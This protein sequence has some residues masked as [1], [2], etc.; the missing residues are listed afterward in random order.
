M[1]HDTIISPLAEVLPDYKL[2]R[3][4]VNGQRAIKKAKG[5]YLPTPD[6][7]DTSVAGLARY[8]TYLGRAVFYGVT[9]R[10]LRGLVG[11]V[12]DKDPALEIPEMLRPLIADIS[13]S[14]MTL[15]EQAEESLSDNVALGRT[16][17]LTDYPVTEGPV[18]RAEALAGNIL[19]TIVRYKAE[20]IIN[21]R[22]RRIGARLQTTLVVLREDAV[23]DDDGF[24]EELETHYRV[25]R[26][27][28][29]GNYTVAI[30]DPSG[31]VTTRTPLDGKG[32]PFKEIPF[33]FVGAEDNTPKVNR[34][35]LLDLANLN[36]A[37]F[38]NSADYEESVFMLGQPTPVF[39]GLTKQ[40]VDE[41]MTTERDDGHGVKRKESAVYLGA[42]GAVSLPEG[43][44]ATLL[45]VAPNTLAFEAMKH[46]E[47]QMLAIGAKLVE[48]TGTQQTA[49]EATID[50]VMDNSVLATAARNVS[51]AYVRCL[52]W[53]LQFMTGEQVKDDNIIDYKLSTD[54][55]ACML[56]AQ[57][58]ENIVGMWIKRAIT[59]EE[60][61]W[62][63][64]RTG[65]AYEDD[66]TAKASIASE[67]EEGI[68]FEA[69]AAAALQGAGTAPPARDDA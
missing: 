24:S 63:L 23:V 65:T 57:D 30:Y 2:I 10:T 27:D 52:Q 48:N 46:K 36:I 68:D 58:R 50:S 59:F 14:G 53:A 1:S 44:T 28:A 34:P 66:E 45:Q 47:E 17:L 62:N 5:A 69:K 54:F 20:D 6:P 33:E 42:R 22:Q 39:A 43:G 29:A 55:A 40:W 56:T 8:D 3:D 32:L 31:N 15:D 21:W 7:T 61:R 64:K 16:G 49:T 19:P 37:H 18:T 13:G 11:L 9:G 38:R 35:P 51:K 60:M 41:V 4:C 12:F 26:I 67:R 25:L